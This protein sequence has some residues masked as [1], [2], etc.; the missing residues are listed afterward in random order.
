MNRLHWHAVAILVAW[1]SLCTVICIGCAGYLRTV[2]EH[3]RS[4]ALAQA[5]TA[6]ELTEQALLR[7]ADG[8]MSVLEM[9]HARMELALRGDADA[10]TVIDQR[11]D[12]II[13]PQRFGV[14]AASFVD[15]E[16]IIRWT[17]RGQP[18]GTLRRRPGSVW[19]R[20]PRRRGLRHVGAHRQPPHRLLDLT[21]RPAD[22]GPHGRHSRHGPGGV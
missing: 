16:G 13:G 1:A 21:G 8:L 12:E 5:E 20:H 2:W 9:V 11:M 19:P 17:L 7:T 6:A 14:R 22:G 18:V 4:A 10:A 15:P 3:E